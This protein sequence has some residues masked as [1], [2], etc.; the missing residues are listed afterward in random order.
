MNSRQLEMWRNQY[1]I[2]ELTVTLSSGVPRKFFRERGGGGGCSTNSVEDRGQRER[3]LGAAG[4]SQGFHL[5]CKWVKPVFWLGCYNVF[6]T[7]LGIRFSFVTTS[8]FRGRG[9]NPQSLPPRY[10]TDSRGLKFLTV[11][12]LLTMRSRVRF[13][14]LP[15][16]FFLLGEVPHS[17]HG[18]ANL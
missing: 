3:D 11:E 5:I 17:H 13:Q 4:P 10:A 16:E 1:H 2:Q 6:F 9:L 18:L 14:V 8:Q 15:W 12:Q 7:E